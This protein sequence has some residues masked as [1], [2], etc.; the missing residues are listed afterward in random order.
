[1]NIPVAANQGGRG[2][3]FE[4]EQTT[5]ALGEVDLERLVV[6]AGEGLDEAAQK[7]SVTSVAMAF[8]ELLPMIPLFERYGN[9]PCLEGERAGKWPPDSDPILQNSP[10]A[11]N[12]TIM[13]MYAGRL[14]PA[15]GAK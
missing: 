13:L 4:L 12:F 10:Y 14:T 2:M 11:D 15:K 6:E 1:H 9:N 7:K 8:N 3:G 5:K